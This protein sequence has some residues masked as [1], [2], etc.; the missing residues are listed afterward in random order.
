MRIRT[1]LLAALLTSL[2]ATS[3]AHAWYGDVFKSPSGN[4]VCKYRAGLD[5]VTCGRFNDKRIIS[6]TAWGYPREGYRL[7]WRGQRVHVLGY[8]EYYRGVGSHITC[9]SFTNGVRC[10]NW[11]GHGFF[12]SREVLN[13]W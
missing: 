4:L 9:G 7:D 11:R 10:T 6:M 2:C 3:Q 12:I 8:G 5:T 1:L 13:R